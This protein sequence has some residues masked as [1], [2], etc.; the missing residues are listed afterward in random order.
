MTIK[1]AAKGTVCLAALFAGSVATADVTAGDVWAD[2][3][4][5]FE[6]YGEGAVSIGNETEAGGTLTVSDLAFVFDDSEAKITA[7][8]PS[9]VF[10]ELGNGTVSVTMSDGY[11]VDIAFA[12]EFGEPG[13]IKLMVNQN[14]LSMIVSGDPAR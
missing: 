12:S 10:T 6:M 14:N 3:Q 7:T 13:S 1:S 2:W 11:P 9:I 4:K 5:N 8:I